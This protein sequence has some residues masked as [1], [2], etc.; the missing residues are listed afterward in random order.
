MDTDYR[1]WVGYKQGP[2]GRWRWVA[3]YLP[4]GETEPNNLEEAK[5]RKLRVACVCPVRGYESEQ[6]AIEAAEGL[7]NVVGE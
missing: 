1:T 2:K 4:P 6:E 5:R 3:Y 7:L